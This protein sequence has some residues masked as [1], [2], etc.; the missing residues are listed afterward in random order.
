M[1]DFIQLVR[2]DTS[3][4]LAFRNLRRANYTAVNEI[5]FYGK[6]LKKKAGKGKERQ[7]RTSLPDNIPK[8][9]RHEPPRDNK[10]VGIQERRDGK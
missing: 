6:K 3:F 4:F 8:E 1:E 10:D 7:M 9:I 2:E 5:N